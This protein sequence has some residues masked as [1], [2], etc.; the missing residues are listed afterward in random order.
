MDIAKAG[1]IVLNV[2]QHV[3]ANYSFQSISKLFKAAT[4]TQIDKTNMDVRAML[5]A[6]V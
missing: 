1:M 5:E 3:K 2:L 4:V 6:A